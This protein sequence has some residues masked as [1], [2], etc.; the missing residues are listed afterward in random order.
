MRPW[1][2]TE[3][4]WSNLGR[5]GIIKETLWLGVTISFILRP[6]NFTGHWPVEIDF[7]K[8]V[9]STEPFRTVLPFEI[10]WDGTF[11]AEETDAHAG[12][13]M[14]DSTE[15]GI[16]NDL[17]RQYLT[18][19]NNVSPF[20]STFLNW[21]FWV[22]DILWVDFEIRELQIHFQ[23]SFVALDRRS[24]IVYI[25]NDRIC[26]V[27]IQLQR[28]LQF[29]RLIDE[30]YFMSHIIWHITSKQTYICNDNGDTRND[31]RHHGWYKSH[32][33]CKRR[34]TKR[35]RHVCPIYFSV[36][37]RIFVLYYDFYEMIWFV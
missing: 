4:F 17:L 24:T 6:L 3:S 13:I 30:S 32:F 8:H 9:E 14:K 37:Y 2:P 22:V 23:V 7:W 16:N 21:I 26:K 15:F 27:L 35:I 28:Y 29:K 20:L 36:L 12:I 5:F 10:I 25:G 34:Y 31:E 11:P 19:L 33:R 1:S 18:N